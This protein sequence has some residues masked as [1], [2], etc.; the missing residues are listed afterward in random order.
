MKPGKGIDELDISRPFT[1]SPNCFATLFCGAALAVV[2]RRRHRKTPRIH[3]GRR[4]A[5]VGKRMADML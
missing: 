2:A 1:S 3:D 4:R 5:D